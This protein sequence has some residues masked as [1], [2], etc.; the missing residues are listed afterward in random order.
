MF[1]REK[2]MHFCEFC[3]YSSSRSTSWCLSVSHRARFAPCVLAVIVK[4][5]NSHSLRLDSATQPYTHRDDR[6]HTHKQTFKSLSRTISNIINNHF[7]LN[8][9]PSDNKF[10]SFALFPTICFYFIFLLYISR[11]IYFLYYSMFLQRFISMNNLP[12][13]SHS[14]LLA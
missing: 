1:E 2:Q 4:I 9:I 8:R 6:T 13:R 5:I 3:I 10:F 14:I 7:D 12:L 11:Y